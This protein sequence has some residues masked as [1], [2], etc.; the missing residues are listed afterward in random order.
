MIELP[1]G[2][3]DERKR[4]KQFGV[5]GILATAIA[6]DVP[7]KVAKAALKIALHELYPHRKRQ[8]GATSFAQRSLALK[9]LAVKFEEL[10]NP[11][12]WKVWEFA[13]HMAEPDVTYMVCI[14]RHAFTIRNGH[15]CD[16]SYN[17]P[18]EKWERRNRVIDR[19]VIKVLGKG[20]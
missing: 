6:A 7:Y 11:M 3:D 19:P 4:L 12:G 18:V 10:T 1:D 16:Q 13:A 14:P 8:R 15:V 17:G 2:F 20:W 5:C 9:K